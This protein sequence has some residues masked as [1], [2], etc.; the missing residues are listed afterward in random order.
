MPAYNN[1]STNNST[2]PLRFVLSNTHIVWLHRR[3]NICPQ[4]AVRYNRV[5]KNKA[6]FGRM[7]D[8]DWTWMKEEVAWALIRNR[9]IIHETVTVIDIVHPKF[10]LNHA[11]FE[12]NRFTLPF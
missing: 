3:K 7:A 6:N 11:F 5:R 4:K 9:K 8:L 10:G 1:L 12:D 2:K